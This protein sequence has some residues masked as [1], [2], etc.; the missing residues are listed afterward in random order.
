M[1]KQVI[2]LLELASK[3]VA[4]MGSPRSRRRAMA[5]AIDKITL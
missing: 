3:K 2:A 5:R 1:D 4:H